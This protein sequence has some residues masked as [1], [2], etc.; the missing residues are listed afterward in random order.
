[1]RLWLKEELALLSK[2]AEALIGTAVER[3]EREVDIVMPG[4]RW[5]CLRGAVLAVPTARPRT[6]YT[7]LQ[8]AQP[9]RWSHWLLSHTWPLVRDVQRLDGIRERVDECPLGR[10]C[11]SSPGR[12]RT[13]PDAPSRIR[14]DRRPCIWS[15]PRSAG[16]RAGFPRPHGQQHGQRERPRLHR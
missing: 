11:A 8:V 13:P 1:M 16:A 5:H 7:H 14:S 15:R 9:V 6:G 2:D 10:R 12:P 4:L 3:A